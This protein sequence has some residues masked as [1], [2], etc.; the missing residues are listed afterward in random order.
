MRVDRAVG[1]GIDAAVTFGAVAAAVVA[2]PLGL[3]RA[4]GQPAAN[5]GMG[6]QIDKHAGQALRRV[7]SVATA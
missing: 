4:R 6:C 7:Q 2:E 5:L 1:A 3:G